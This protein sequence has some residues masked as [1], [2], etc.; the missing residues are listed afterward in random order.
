MM[1]RENAKGFT[2]VE[3]MVVIVLI[4]LLAGT[5]TVAVWPIL[6]KGK[7]SAAKTQL[8][9]FSEALELYR[10]NHNRYPET[11]DGLVQSDTEHN[12]PNGYLKA[13]SEIPLDPWDQEYGYG[14]TTDSYEIWSNGPDMSEN[15]EDDIRISEGGSGR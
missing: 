14:G 5:V 10:L 8:K 11:L 6:F 7:A 3:L 1:R 9:T 4:G 13:T 15:T 12:Q 2:L